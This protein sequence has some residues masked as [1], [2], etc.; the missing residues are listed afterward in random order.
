MIVLK[1]DI[2]VYKAAYAINTRVWSKQGKK[3]LITLWLPKGTRCNFD[4]RDSTRSEAKN[5]CDRA[6]VRRIQGLHRRSVRDKKHGGYYSVWSILPKRYQKAVSGH[7]SDFIYTVGKRV[8]PRF[9]FAK[10]GRECASGV[11][12]FANRNAAKRYSP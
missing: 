1:R 5:R 7:D 8:T 4:P 11:H 6:V 12:F 10:T 3:V 2:E 9:A